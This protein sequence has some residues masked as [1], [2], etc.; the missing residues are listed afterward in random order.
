MGQQPIKL[1][2]SES[3]SMFIICICCIKCFDLFL[4]SQDLL[5]QYLMQRNTANPYP[6]PTYRINISPYP[7]P[8]QTP[9]FNFVPFQQPA[10][11]QRPTQPMLP[12]AIQTYPQ[13]PQFLPPMPN[14]PYAQYPPFLPPSFGMQPP[15]V[16]V[17]NPAVTSK[18]S[19]TLSPTTPNATTST[20]SP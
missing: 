8:N 12:Y 13:Y 2:G 17:V 11:Y 15:I 20:T 10:F 19:T 14:T 18:P 6:N 1:S 9:R 4:S 7:N 5:M 3:G 16:F